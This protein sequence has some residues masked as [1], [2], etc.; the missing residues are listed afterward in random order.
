MFSSVFAPKLVFCT[1]QAQSVRL[2]THHP[3]FETSFFG[4]FVNLVTLS[5]LFCEFGVSFTI[6][7]FPPCSGGPGGPMFAW[8]CPDKRSKTR[9]KES[10]MR[11]KVFL[12][13]KVGSSIRQAAFFFFSKLTST[14]APLPPSTLP[15][16]LSSS[17]PKPLHRS[18]RRLFPSNDAT[19]HYVRSARRSHTQDPNDKY[20]KAKCTPLFVLGPVRSRSLWRFHSDRVTCSPS[21]PFFSPFSHNHPFVCFPSKRCTVNYTP[22]PQEMCVFHIS[23]LWSAFH[24]CGV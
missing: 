8:P 18:V 22:P 15:V 24:S 3:F 10:K 17:K 7:V 13:A 9:R 2:I 12:Q 19:L 1:S 23:R 4:L 16:L 11:Q 5:T 21:L 6:V 14:S 20:W